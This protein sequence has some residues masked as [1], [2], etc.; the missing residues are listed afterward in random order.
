MKRQ[1]IMNYSMMAGKKKKQPADV[2][3]TS[4]VTRARSGFSP[5]ALNPPYIPVALNPFAAVTPPGIY[6]KEFN[7][8]IRST[9]FLRNKK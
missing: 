2:A 4:Q 9:F 1:T 3:S 5:W 6:I 8:V 7:G